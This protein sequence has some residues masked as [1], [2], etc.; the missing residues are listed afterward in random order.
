MLIVDPFFHFAYIEKLEVMKDVV[1]QDGVYRTR[2]C[3]C[4]ERCYCK[5]SRITSF[6]PAHIFGVIAEIEPESAGISYPYA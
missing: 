5:S 2:I 6:T 3:L 4:N 1:Y